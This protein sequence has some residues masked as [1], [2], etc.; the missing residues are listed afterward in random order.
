MHTG[1]MPESAGTFDSEW[2]DSGRT[3]RHC[4]GAMEYR[5]WE[6]SCGGYE[7]EKHRCK[8]CGKGYWIDGPDS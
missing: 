8:E 2:K 7:D 1:P 6:S 4:G 3:C 5:V